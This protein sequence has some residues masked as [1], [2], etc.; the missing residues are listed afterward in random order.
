VPKLIYSPK[1][2]VDLGEQHPFVTSKYRLV[3]EKLESELE[4]LEFI[5]PRNKD[6]VSILYEVHTKRYVE[7]VLNLGLS[8][9][10]ILRLETPLTEEIKNAALVAVAGTIL[11]AELAVKDKV[12]IHVGGGFHHA[13][14]DHGEG[15]CVFNDIA[16]AIK[17]LEKHHGIKKFA[18]V[19]LDVHQG[20]G[21]AKI[22][23]GCKNVFTYSIHQEE[24]YPFPK[25]KSSLDVGLPAFTTDEEYINVLKETIKE[26]IRFNPEVVFY[27]A[28][29]DIYERDQLAQLRV[30][31]YGIKRRD[32]IV[33]EAFRNKPIILTLGGGYAFDVNDTVEI[34]CNTIKVFL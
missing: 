9:F 12:G 19:D 31:K 20:N 34:H 24:I 33:K 6:V 10:E 29:A 13:Y 14:P 21:T 27:Q 23:A 32:E 3:K 15:F 22:F 28:G 5:E 1:Y 17:Y 11:A 8:Y 25:E 18:V 16:C 7:K 26:V 2:E 4:G 30:T